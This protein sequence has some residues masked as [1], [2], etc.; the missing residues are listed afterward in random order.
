MI[1]NNFSG[2]KDSNFEPMRVIWNK[3]TVADLDN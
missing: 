2:S 1:V 3:I